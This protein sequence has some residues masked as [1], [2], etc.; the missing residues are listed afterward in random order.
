MTSKRVL[1]LL[2]TATVIGKK[3][4][5]GSFF[6]VQLLLEVKR[7]WLRLKLL[8]LSK[9][10]SPPFLANDLQ[11]FAAAENF[12]IR[13]K[14]PSVCSS[15]KQTGN[16]SGSLSSRRIPL[17]NMIL[18]RYLISLLLD[19]L[20]I[21]QPRWRHNCILSC[22]ISISHGVFH[23]LKFQVFMSFVIATGLQQMQL[24]MLLIIPFSCF[25]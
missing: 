17:A 3:S 16:C 9:S 22:N 13:K 11:R 4:L 12:A 14:F 24:D 8:F 20:V 7:A 18:W 25:T 6:Y 2:F 1:G 10:W 19:E 21:S 5:F 15:H 23:T